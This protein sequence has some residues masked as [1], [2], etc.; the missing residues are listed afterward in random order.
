MEGYGEQ[1]KSGPHKITV[2]NL[3]TKRDNFGRIS[4]KQDKK[5]IR[6]MKKRK[7]RN[8]TGMR[9]E[10]VIHLSEMLSVLEKI[11]RLSLNPRLQRALYKK[12]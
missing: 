5:Q 7:D 4:F 3:E 10:F 12:N 9:P 2:E 11:M 1:N 8:K 6:G